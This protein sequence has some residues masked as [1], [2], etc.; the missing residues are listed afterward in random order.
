MMSGSGSR[1]NEWWRRRHEGQSA[2]AGEEKGSRF[3]RVGVP[4]VVI[5][6]GV[7]CCYIHG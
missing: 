7:F 2:A 3:D 5:V 6:G 1:G 4:V